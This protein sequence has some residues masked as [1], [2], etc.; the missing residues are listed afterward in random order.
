MKKLL[1]ILSLPLLLAACEQAREAG[2]ETARE[3]TGGNMIEQGRQ[4][5]QQLHDIDQQQQERFKQ[6]DQQ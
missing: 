6:L 3:I 4:T 1:L 2:D 5:Q